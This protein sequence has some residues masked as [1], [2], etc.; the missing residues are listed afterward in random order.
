MPTCFEFG[1]MFS[2]TPFPMTPTGVKENTLSPPPKPLRPDPPARPAPPFSFLRTLKSLLLPRAQ[3]TLPSPYPR[4]KQ[5]RR[6]VLVT[7]VDN[8]TM[9][10]LRFNESEFGKICFNTLPGR[11]G[12][13]GGGV[14]GIKG[15]SG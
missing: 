9:S 2:K 13:S 6:N 3:K 8:G 1:E 14:G 7:V 4:L 12:G 15:R 11:S 10:F 5:G